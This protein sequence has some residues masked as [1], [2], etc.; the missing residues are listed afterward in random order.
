MWPPWENFDSEDLR[1]PV[2]IKR[3]SR[4]LNDDGEDDEA[5]HDDAA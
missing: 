1:L 3:T 2:K 5:D 4:T